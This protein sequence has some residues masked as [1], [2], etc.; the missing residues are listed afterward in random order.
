MALFSIVPMPLNCFGVIKPSLT[1]I[2]A[3]INKLIGSPCIVNTFS[4]SNFFKSPN[5]CKYC[6][7][8]GNCCTFS[9]KNSLAAFWVFSNFIILGLP[10]VAAKLSKVLYALLYKSTF[11]INTFS[12]CC[13]TDEL[14]ALTLSN[15][16]YAC[17]SERY[18]LPPAISASDFATFPTGA[19][20]GNTPINLK[21]F[22]PRPAKGPCP[23]FKP[24]NNGNGRP[25][26][27]ANCANSFCFGPTVPKRDLIPLLKGL[28]KN[29]DN[30]DAPVFHSIAFF[31]ATAVFVS[32][33][34][35][36]SPLGISDRSSAKAD[37]ISTPACS[38]KVS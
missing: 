4:M 8:S 10:E 19:T 20:K 29:G 35:S 12:A 27:L 25:L 36:T 32:W 28:N 14:M 24:D 23:S 7:N 13:L 9:S 3:F 2:I 30:K 34:L 22:L 26:S 38:F 1:P 18:L 37:A 11:S 15:G 16:E 21:K 17:K 31:I 6:S 33:S 5:P